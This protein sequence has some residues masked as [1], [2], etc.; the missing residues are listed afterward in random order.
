[1]Q[2]NNVKVKR[3][4]FSIVSCSFSFLALSFALTAHAQDITTG[5]AGHWKF[6]E[7][8]GTTAS[9]SSGNNNT[10]TL[11]NGPTWTAGKIGGAVN[12]D[13]GDD[14]V[15]KSDPNIVE[16]VN[17]MTIS[18]WMKSNLGFKAVNEMLI[19][20]NGGG[21]DTFALQWSSAENINFSVED[22]IGVD[23]SATF[24]DGVLDTNWHHIVGVMNGSNI[25]VYVDTVVGDIQGSISTVSNSSANPIEIGATNGGQFFN[26]QI[27]EVRV[28]NRALSVSDI[29]ALYTYTGGP[30]PTPDVTP[31]SIPANLFA[32]AQSSSQ[33]NLS[34]TA[35][36][37][38]VGVTGYR[39][40]RGG[41][42]IASPSTTSYSDTGLSPS[43]T[44]SYTI[45]AVDAAGNV[46]VQSS[47]VVATTQSPPSPDTQAPTSPTNL[48]ATA[49]SS[50]QINLS[51]TQST[52]NVG[53][54]GYQVER[55]QGS[56][57][58]T[59]TQIASP[60]GTSYSDAGLSTNSS[61]SYRVRAVDAAGNPSG[62]STVASATTQ[63]SA[64]SPSNLVAGYSFDEG[65][66][67]SASDVSGNNNTGTL[68]GSSLWVAG[69][70]ATALDFNGTSQ[71]VSVLDSASLDLNGINYLAAELRGM[72]NQN[73]RS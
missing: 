52:D 61:Y 51:W 39:V 59:F 65:I 70:Y 11:T 62:Y 10:G 9:D 42:Q 44:Y 2:N 18:F 16:G 67:T 17:Q 63:A 8:I 24:T 58:A 28:Y 13:G 36:I 20:Q 40:Y 35:S 66:G 55:C 64:P 3:I 34:W 1:M 4:L 30:P 41:T 7:T 14:Y 68:I 19:A 26:G 50:S 31:P 21:T 73:S 54:A 71:Y 60:A 49:I 57:C 43:T 48:S 15:T 37:D 47:S 23:Q 5:L 29:Q 38:N 45:A 25:R 6:D 46:S 69:K 22:T 53:V 33:I 12:F 56:G 32:V 72:C 27:D